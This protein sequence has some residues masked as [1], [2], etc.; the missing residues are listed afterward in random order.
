[1]IYIPE[2]CKLIFDI[3]ENNG[4]ECFAVGGC[5]RDSIMGNTPSDWDFTTNATPDEIC[6][7]FSCYNTID[8]G[9]DFGTICV[10]IDSEPFEI[11]TYRCDGAYSD[12]RHPDT[13]SFTSSITDDLA[14]R[15]FTV[16]SIAYNEKTGFVDPFGG[17]CDIERRLIRCTGIAKERFSEDA[18]RILR[19]VRFASRLGFAIDDETSEAMH[20]LK[21]NLLQ[22]HPQ[23]IRKELSGIIM[24][25]YAPRI[26]SEYRD[27][28]SVI[29]PEIVPM[30]DLVQNNPHHIYDVWTHT[31][32]ALSNASLDDDLVRFAVFFHDIGKPSCKTTDEAGVDHF[33]KHPHKSAQ[34]TEEILKRFGFSHRFIQDVCALI[35]HHDERFKQ[36][37]ADIKRVLSD[38]GE[39]LFAKLM[40]VNLADTLAQSEYQREYKLSHREKV[41]RRA[42]EIIVNGECYKLSQLA[43]NGSDLVSM[44]FQGKAISNALNNLLRL[45]IKGKCKNTREDLLYYAKSLPK[46]DV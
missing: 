43:L 42:D 5:V 33:K 4:Y 41:T 21:D 20:L 38:I 24:A 37:D 44:G 6:R 27:V 3:L 26:L 39:D 35:K 23:R 1:M 7:C 34:M 13:V 28:L 31:L 19:A 8:V 11:T 18:L 46:E 32:K 40:C 36:M 12:S 2:K 30:F 25:E 29:L 9:R 16:N 10:V 17:V 45:V 15:D 14:R 22:V